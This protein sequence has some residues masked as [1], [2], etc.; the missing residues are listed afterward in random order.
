MTKQE[1]AA[2][3]SES[4]RRELLESQRLEWCE[5]DTDFIA[6]LRTIIDDL[7]ALEDKFDMLL[8]G[9]LTAQ[10]PGLYTFQVLLEKA[11]GNEPARPIG[12]IN[13]DTPSQAIERAA[14]LYKYPP[15][16]LTVRQVIDQPGELHT[17]IDSNYQ[18]AAGDAY[19][20]KL[21]IDQF[22]IKRYDG[23]KWE[24]ITMVTSEQEVSKFVDGMRYLGES[25]NYR[26]YYRPQ[27]ADHQS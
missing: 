9:F 18:P 22:T 23:T 16:D 21:W 10:Q 2:A 26:Q 8:Q 15:H 17:P 4:L 13:A 12:P 19:I 1:I 14:Q 6:M 24:F 25:K 5:H 11:D 3:I 7:V 20:V 27:S